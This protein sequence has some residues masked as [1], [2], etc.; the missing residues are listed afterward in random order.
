M[1]CQFQF[2]AVWRGRNAANY[3]KRTEHGALNTA[4]REPGNVAA[5]ATP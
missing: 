1:E 4:N 5:P 2:R 3:E